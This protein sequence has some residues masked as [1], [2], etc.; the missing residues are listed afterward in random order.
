[1][2][3]SLKLEKLRIPTLKKKLQANAPILF[4]SFGIIAVMALILWLNGRT[5]ICTCGY[6]KFWHGEVNSSGNS[7]HLFDPY[8][9][10]HILHGL[11]FYPL[12][13]LI[14]RKLPTKYR[15][16]IALLIEAGWEILEN[17]N[18]IINRYRAATISFDYFGDSIVNSIGDL[19][20]MSLGFW[21]ASKAKIWQT[22]ALFFVIETLLLF[23]I[24]DNL[25]INIIQLIHPIDA[26]K[27]WQYNAGAVKPK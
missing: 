23:W 8:S 26:I 13:W 25:T 1:M 3:L 20:S 21:I 18:F 14:T 16:L 27:Q 19:I 10:S 4:A 24:R 11:L 5:P 17:S 2:P 6:I 9:F 15:F 22:I 12:L 7:Q